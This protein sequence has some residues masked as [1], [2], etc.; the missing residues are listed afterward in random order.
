[1]PHRVY[2]KDIESSRNVSVITQSPTEPVKGSLSAGAV[3][4][5]VIAVLLLVAVIAAVIFWRR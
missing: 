2:I 1:M 5:P 3:V 4:G